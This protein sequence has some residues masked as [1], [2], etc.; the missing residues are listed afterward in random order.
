VT[1]ERRHKLLRW[2]CL[3]APLLSAASIALL[4]F[5]PLRGRLLAGAH[6]ISP[7]LDAFTSVAP[8]MGWFVLALGCSA[9]TA[10]DLVRRRWKTGAALVLPAILVTSLVF[11]GHLLVVGTI[12]AAGCGFALRGL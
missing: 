3:L 7:E 11:L 5:T 12:A 2:L 6:A 4:A 10:I 8:V 9:F 1:H